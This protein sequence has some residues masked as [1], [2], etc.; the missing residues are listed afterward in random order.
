[1]ENL[2]DRLYRIIFETDTFAGKAFD[3]IL[4]ILIALSVLIVILHTVDDIKEYHGLFIMLEWFFTITFSIEYAVRLFCAKNSFKYAFSF[5]GLIDLLAI[6][7]GF[8][9]P[10]VSGASHLIVLRG[11]RLLRVFLVFKL[12]RFI[13]Q[14]NFLLN[15]LKKGFRKIIVFLG[16]VL[17]IVIIM[18]ALMYLIEGPENGFVS[19]PK[20]MYW[21]IVTLT[22]VG[23]GDISPQTAMGQILSSII[24]LLGYGIIAVPTGILSAEIVIGSKTKTLSCPACK[25]KGLEQDSK[26]CRFCGATLKNKKN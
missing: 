12:G 5:F 1:M 26:Y 23:Y 7:P 2:R 19:I 13:S 10:L 17:T 22:T 25:K 16:T 14:A 6:L 9:T 3:I 4:L 11:I 8:F 24:M 15:A 21:A 20:S 18:G